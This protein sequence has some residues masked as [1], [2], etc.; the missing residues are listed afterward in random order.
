MR[1]NN[2]LQHDPLNFLKQFTPAR[3]VLGHSG[4][5]I[6][7]LHALNLRLAHAQARD[8]VFSTLII[9][10]LQASLGGLSLLSYCVQSKA[11]SRETYLSDPS[12]GRIL[13][14]TSRELLASLR[15]GKN[16]VCF[17][18]AD[19]LS[20]E[21]IN[22]HAHAFLERVLPLLAK[23]K[24]APVIIAQQARV[25]L[26]DEIGMLLNSE[27]AVMLVGERP[28]L[29]SP[30][31]MGIYV[32][33]TPKPGTTDERRN[34]ISNIHENGIS[35]AEAA[36]TLSY[37]LSKMFEFKTSGITLKDERTTGSHSVRNIR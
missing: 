4:N 2:E 1:E 16:D 30:H 23:K 7:T 19:G 5:S 10:R 11:K 33:H 8:A 20:A 27:I 29:S 6:P 13:S 37:L 24:I 12:A 15:N 21:A 22:I 9:D 36:E 18:I 26:S 3:I 31:S 35:Y 32:T 28:G 34:C 25:A 17:I 14:D